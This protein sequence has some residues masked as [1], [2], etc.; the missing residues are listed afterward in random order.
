MQE[1]QTKYIPLSHDKSS[2]L[3]TIPLHGDKLFE[4]RSRNVKWTFQNGESSV[5]RLEGLEPEFADWHA[6][7]TLFKVI[8]Y[9]MYS[10]TI[11]SS[12]NH[13]LTSN[14]FVKQVLHVVTQH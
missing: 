13:S 9:L 6:K 2:V 4:E 1:N 12:C 8:M 11:H 5:E 14:N 3:T 10:T 7:F